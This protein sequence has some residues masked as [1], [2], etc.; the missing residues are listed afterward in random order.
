MSFDGFDERRRRQIIY[1]HLPGLC[2]YGDL[3]DTSKRIAL[4]REKTY[5]SVS[6]KEGAAYSVAAV[7]GAYARC[8]F[9]V[10]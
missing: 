7:D 1:Q 4:S 10:P 5:V 8:R 9:Q 3:K 2:P 6:R